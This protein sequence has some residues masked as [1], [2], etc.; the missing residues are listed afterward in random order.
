VGTE[1]WAPRKRDQRD[2]N[3]AREAAAALHRAAGVDGI[4]A[5]QV[6]ELRRPCPGSRVIRAIPVIGPEAA[7]AGATAF[8]AAADCILSTRIP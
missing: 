6:A 1:T 4:Q 5:D 2:V 7:L 3:V 8:E